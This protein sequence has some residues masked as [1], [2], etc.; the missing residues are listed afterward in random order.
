MKRVKYILRVILCVAVLFA[1]VFLLFKTVCD[2]ILTAEKIAAT[3]TPTF[4]TE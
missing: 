2:S 4:T 1:A 3:T